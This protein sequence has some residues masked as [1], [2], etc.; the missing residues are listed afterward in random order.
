MLADGL[1]SYALFPALTQSVGL[2]AVKVGD[3][4]AEG[5]AAHHEPVPPNWYHGGI[6]GEYRNNTSKHLGT[7]AEA[8]VALDQEAA[9]F[10]NEVRSPRNS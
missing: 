5:L 8:V 10:W 9:A 3:V 4:R 1:K 2:Y 6:R 7:K